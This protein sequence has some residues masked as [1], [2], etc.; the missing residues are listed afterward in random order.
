[1]T[2]NKKKI[3][4]DPVYGFI[5][6]PSDI[7]YDVIQ[8]P[9][10]Q[11]LR[12]VKQLGLTD[13]VYP[14]ATHTR[15]EHVIGATHLMHNAINELKFKGIK[16]S[17]DETAGAL[18]AILMHDLGH[19]PFS[20]TLEGFFAEG[21]SHE[22]ISLLFMERINADLD[23]RIS[24]GIEI[25]K[26]KYKRHF[27]HNL[28]SGQLDMDRLD[29]LR[30]D[31]F[32]TG[33]SE[34]VVGSDRIIKM[35]NVKDNEL[36]IEAKGIYS[37]EK[38]LI[39]RRIMYWQVYL[40]K[41]VVAAELMLLQILRRAKQLIRKRTVFT[42]PALHFFLKND[43]SKPDFIRDDS[44]LSKFAQLDDYDVIACV[45]QW[46]NDSDKTLSELSKRLINRDLFK[47]EIQPDI[48][49]AERVQKIRQNTAEQ[50]QLDDDE[51]DFFVLSNRISNR[52]YRTDKASG[53]NILQK[54]GTLKDIAEASDISNISALTET[55]EKHILLYP[56]ESF[57][58]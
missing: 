28:V 26:N 55:V 37:V 51:L 27:L 46:V 8:H 48:F 2:S 44:V 13:Y 42:T 47:L 54:N 1:M 12:R 23:G 11:R 18:L 29:Y 32:F 6:I 19:G 35:L 38:F 56:K 14:G 52:A 33:V 40:H 45:K 49:D 34:G 31:S 5:N 3:I 7:I 58:K 17:P 30:R 25:F 15:F 53:I 9:Y 50:F 39:A 43:I 16:I 24:T 22:D 10:F 20:H 41:T 21:I 36:V 4:N 57:V